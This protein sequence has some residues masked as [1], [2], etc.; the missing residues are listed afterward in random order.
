[1]HTFL[2]TGQ[3]FVLHNSFFFVQL[4]DNLSSE[5][6]S[7]LKKF[8]NKIFRNLSCQNFNCREPQLYVSDF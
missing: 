5:N 2:G 8:K 1:M 4:H 7:F 6:S 3:K